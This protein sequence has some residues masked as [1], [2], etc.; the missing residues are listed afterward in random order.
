MIKW[1]RGKL[2]KDKLLQHGALLMSAAVVSH[3]CNI[4]FQMIMGRGLGG[5]EYALLC[6]LLGFV[7]MATMPLGAFSTAVSHSSSILDQEGRAGDVSKLVRKWLFR[8]GGIGSVI[9]LLCLVFPSQIAA[10][11]HLDRK[12]PVIII[13]VVFFLV[14]NTTVI[15]G[16][17]NGLQMFTTA[18]VGQYASAILR[19]VA[20]WGLIHLFFAAAGW[21]LLGHALGLAVNLGVVFIFLWRRLH[22]AEKTGLPIPSIRYYVGLSFLVLNALSFLFRADMLLVKHYL[23]DQAAVFA[24]A[25]TIGH[26]VIFL[27]MPIARAMFPK[28]ASD[29]RS[30]TAE[31][32]AVLRKSL[33]Y[34][35]ICTLPAAVA[36]TFFGWIP[37][38][39][40]F[41]LHE[42]SKEL[43][44]LVA[45]MGWVMFPVA[46]VN[47]IIYFS[48]AQKRFINTIPCLLSALFY[49]AG[50]AVWHESVWD[51]VAVAGGATW[52]CFLL[53]LPFV[54]NK[55][56][57]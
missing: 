11:M 17:A 18:T 38:S 32:Y 7:N 28:V 40:V 2:S 53:S 54:R 22:N 52:G 56:N 10:F 23:P 41:G 6:T 46:L 50:T 12:A 45:A 44:Y 5:E 19:L 39:V 37:L 57:V 8:V 49:V 51:I 29:G 20:S 43:L 36:C 24:Y 34:T 4:L 31:H 30:S 16:A 47:I 1:L 21:G 13:G 25:T 14:C 9:L 35:F 42:P 26:I 33:F 55:G 27:P 3:I 48:L 15:G